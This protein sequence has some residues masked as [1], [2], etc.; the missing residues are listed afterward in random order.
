MRADLQGIEFDWFAV[1][2]EGNLAI[3]ASAGEGFIPEP[4]SL[5]FTKHEAVSES[6]ASP[7][8]GTMSVW[9]DYAAQGLFVFDWSLPS[10]PYERRAAP[11]T[12][13]AKELKERILA[14]GQLP[15]ITGSFTELQRLFQWPAT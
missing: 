3:F 6:L 9:N 4:V 2:D 15:T 14:I 1:D 7:N 10:G 5:Y 13:I 11:S 12:P 8:T